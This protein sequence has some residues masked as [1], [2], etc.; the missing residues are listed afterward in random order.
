MMYRI[1][2]TFLFLFTSLITFGQWIE[3]PT[4]H[5][6]NPEF[7]RKVN[8]LLNYSVDVIDV[9][10]LHSTLQ[11]YT[12]LDIRELKEYEVSHLPGA[13]HFGYDYPKWN[14]LND[15]QKDEK[16]LVYCS[17]GYRS[18]KIGEKL[19]KKGYTNVRNLYGSIFEWANQDYTMHDS[20]G[21]AI[22]AVHGYN[23]KWS[24]WVTN[25]NIR[26]DY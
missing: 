17:I 16:I 14:I 6:E 3:S 22:K 10:D 19:L 25:E 18:E 8:K 11:E 2:S 7:N 5:C 4:G 20:N 12:L 1:V 23:K 9:A 21:K 26:V 24:K 15:I 13:I